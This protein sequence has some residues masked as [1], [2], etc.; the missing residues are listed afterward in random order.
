[1]ALGKALSFRQGLQGL[2]N[3]LILQLLLLTFAFLEQS[4]AARPTELLS[5][6]T[7]STEPGSETASFTTPHELMS[8]GDHGCAEAGS[9][10]LGGP[11]AGSC[12]RG[13]YVRM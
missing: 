10:D 9:L 12:R 1:M 11:V 6:T 13:E 7:L 3:R 5:K 4:D 2:S 8:P